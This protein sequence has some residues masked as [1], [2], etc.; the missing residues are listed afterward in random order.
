M[1]GHTGLGKNSKL[2]LVMGNAEDNANHSERFTSKARVT[3]S[4]EG[5]SFTADIWYGIETLYEN[6]YVQM[7]IEAW[8]PEWKQVALDYIKAHYVTR[9]ALFEVTVEPVY[10]LLNVANAS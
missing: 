4:S 10:E 8:H 2:R 5:S 3:F 7:P 9:P 1:I 6:R